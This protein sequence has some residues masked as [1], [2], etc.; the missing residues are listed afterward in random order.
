MSDIPIPGHEIVAMA[1]LE[2][3]EPFSRYQSLAYWV[4]RAFFTQP[5]PLHPTSPERFKP[6]PVRL[7]GK[8]CFPKAPAIHVIAS[9]NKC[10]RRRI[11]RSLSA[12]D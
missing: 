7:A 11:Y 10:S 12:Y 9:N 6:S 3:L 2:V 5:W 1:T 8:S 4:G